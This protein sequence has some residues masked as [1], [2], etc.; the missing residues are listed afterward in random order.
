MPRGSTRQ[1]SSQIVPT[2]HRTVLIVDSQP[3]KHSEKRDQGSQSDG[4]SPAVKLT[5]SGSQIRGKHAARISSRVEDRRG[6]ASASAPKFDGRHPEGTL[7]GSNCAQCQR[8]PGHDPDWISRNTPSIKSP[9][10]DNIPAMGT[11]FL[12]RRRPNAV[13]SRSVSQPPRGM[14]TAIASGGIAA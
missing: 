12:P 13:S 2:L 3:E 5:D 14:P 11:S 8:E 7:G 6:A 9:A 4:V 1:R 10:P